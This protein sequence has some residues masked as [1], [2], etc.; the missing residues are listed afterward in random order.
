MADFKTKKPKI[1]NGLDERKKQPNGGLRKKEDT[2]KNK[3]DFSER[4]AQP[5]G[6]LRRKEDTTKIRLTLTRERHNQNGGL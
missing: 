6:G 3:V 1:R 5:N 2:T 4:K